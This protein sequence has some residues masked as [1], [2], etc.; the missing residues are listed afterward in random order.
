MKRKSKFR[1]SGYALVSIISIGAAS[2]LLLMALAFIVTNSTRAVSRNKYTESLRNAAEIGIDYAV[3]KYNSEF[4][5][6]LDPGTQDS[7]GNLASL[8]TP[9]PSTYLQVAG[10]NGGV[11]SGAPN[12]TV[13]ITVTELTSSNDWLTLKQMSSAYSAQL[14]PN[15]TVA[16][17]WGSPA[18]ATPLNV[19][20]GG[21]RIV[22][23]TA[24]NGIF[25]RTIRVILEAQLAGPGSIPPSQIPNGQVA[26]GYFN[27]PLLSNQTMNLQPLTGPLL[28]RGYNSQTGTYDSLHTVTP[29]LQGQASYNA[30]D[31]NVQSNQ[32]VNVGN[33]GTSA[34]STTI[35]GD[36]T[37][38]NVAAPGAVASTPNGTIEG[39]LIT[40][41]TVDDTVAFTPDISQAQASDTVKANA[42]ISSSN[43]SRVGQNLSAPVAQSQS[44]SAATLASSPGGAGATPIA[45]LANIANAVQPSLPDGSP[46]PAP[47]IGAGQYV[48]QG[49]S[50]DGI[51][52]SLSVQNGGPVGAGS[53]I[54]I[55]VDSVGDSTA[56][57]LDTSKLSLQAS[58]DARNFQIFYEGSEAVNINLAGGKPFTGLIYAP[59]A[60]VNVTGSGIFNGGVVAGQ[61]NVSMAGTMNLYTDLGATSGSAGAANAST[62]LQYVGS[63]PGKPAMT[64]VQGWQPITWQEFTV[65]TSF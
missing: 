35:N 34:F 16:A 62:G 36:V 7:S 44:S 20:D 12:I 38:S 24:S 19:P 55:Y 58:G 15:N 6:S 21:F 45:S 65:G 18:S 5:C 26:S 25:S 53:A 56:I 64:Y 57:N 8:Q 10:P 23:S 11:D 43:Q 51:N 61:L 27:I 4:P 2:L 37:V 46:A 49:L 41:G 54:K 29:T 42:D 9:L 47:S 13:T 63:S 60:N 22:E 33:G 59:N 48:S 14:D 28:V 50:T 3:S 17:G 32:A 39:R 30:Y 52:T 31:L 40:N 1:R